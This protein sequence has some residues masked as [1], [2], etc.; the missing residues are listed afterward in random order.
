MGQGK[1][2]KKDRVIESKFDE[3]EGGKAVDG[4]AGSAQ[5]FFSTHTNNS[6]KVFI[7][8]TYITENLLKYNTC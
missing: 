1:K 6:H 4:E 5:L 3:R 8:I 2:K 7:S